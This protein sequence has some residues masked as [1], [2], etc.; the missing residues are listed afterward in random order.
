MKIEL[1]LGVLES[2]AQLRQL[3][4]R[5]SNNTFQDLLQLLGGLDFD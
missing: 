2:F 5:E 1:Q 3:E 4:L